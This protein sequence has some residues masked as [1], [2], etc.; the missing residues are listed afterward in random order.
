MEANLLAQINAGKVEP[1]I[2]TMKSLEQAGSSSS[3]A[4]LY[5]KLGKLLEKELERLKT[6][7]NTTALKKMQEV[8]RSFLTALTESKVGPEL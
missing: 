7:K 5:F 6:T 3:R 2:A 1:A 8:Y 4:Q